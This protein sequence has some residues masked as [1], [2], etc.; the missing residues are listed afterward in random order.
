[1]YVDSSLSSRIE[2][3]SMLPAQTSNI[4]MI[5]QMVFSLLALH[6]FTARFVW[7]SWLD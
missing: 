7:V 1:M 2:I 4:Y 6:S 5:S 3:L